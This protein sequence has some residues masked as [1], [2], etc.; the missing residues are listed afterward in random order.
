[1]KKES[2]IEEMEELIGEHEHKKENY[3]SKL[4]GHQHEHCHHNLK[5]KDL[6]I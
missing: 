1:M 5:H 6:R 4:H 2:R 3:S